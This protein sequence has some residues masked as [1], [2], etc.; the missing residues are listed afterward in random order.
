MTSTQIDM[1]TEENDVIGTVT[2]E[3]LRKHN[4][5]HRTVIL[6]VFN[7]NNELYIRKRSF[8]KDLYPG[9]YGASCEG[10]VFKDETFEDAAERKLKAELGIEAP[11]LFVRS[12]RYKDDKV[13][14]LGHIYAMQFE[15]QI[16]LNKE[17]AEGKFV[18]LEK[19]HEML[20]KEK[21][22]PDMRQVLTK[23]LREIKDRALK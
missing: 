16:K 4:M 8:E 12:I 18:D 7:G 6:F 17:G 9:L 15:G 20:E 21:F 13:N 1:I 11:F 22:M 14:Y 19:V 10:L 2:R 23:H 3:E 5:L